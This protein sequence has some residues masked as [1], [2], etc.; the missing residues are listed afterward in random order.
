MHGILVYEMYDFV[1]ISI[2]LYGI[3]DRYSARA[4]KRKRVVLIQEVD[5]KLEGGEA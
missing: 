5:G 2:M 3:K 1:C 4:D